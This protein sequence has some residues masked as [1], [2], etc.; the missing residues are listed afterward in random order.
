VYILN[1]YKIKT[2]DVRLN[3][4]FLRLNGHQSIYDREEKIMYGHIYCILNT[5]NN[6][7][8]IGQTT[9]KNPKT[10]WSGHLSAFR[11]G[12]NICPKLNRA[13]AKYGVE[14]FTF[15][16]LDVCLSQS[17]L[18]EREIF[19]IKKYNTISEGYN[20]KIG[21]RGGKV[22]KSKYEGMFSPQQ[23][24]ENT[25]WTIVD[26]TIHPPS[27]KIDVM[28]I[29]G[30]TRRVEVY[31]LTHGKTTSCGCR[32]GYLTDGT[33]YRNLNRLVRR[34]GSA[35]N[36]PY[37]DLRSKFQ[38]QHARCILTEQPLNQTTAYLA[39]I[40]NSVPLSSTNVAWVYT[41]ISS[42]THSDGVMGAAKIATQIQ[43]HVK[44]TNIFDKLGMKPDSGEK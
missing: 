21:G 7:K 5:K 29:C 44:N 6:K 12:K 8:Y 35:S 11:R 20:I 40:D 24:I 32:G 13:F 28:C 10:R 19:W 34:E 41:G 22:D 39:K 15:S 25:H 30:E 9:A 26:G 3:V 4:N 17:E 14:N 27:A 2:V 18:D 1:T 43:H 36:V 42:L 38:D 33:L 16:I 23:K 31:A 37:E